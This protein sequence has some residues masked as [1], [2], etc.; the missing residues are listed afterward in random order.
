MER[1]LASMNVLLSDQFLWILVLMILVLLGLA[2]FFAA[3][4]FLLRLRTEKEARLWVRLEESWEPTLLEAL[5]DPGQL[6]ALWRKVGEQHHLH[7]LEFVLRYAQRL[8]GAERDALRKAA[9]PYLP[10]I[11]P[12]LKHRRMGIR[13][14]GV[15]TLGTLGL[16]QFADEIRDAVND[17]SPFVAAIAAR[18]LAH[19][20]GAE[21]ASDLC[22]SLARFDKFRIWYLVDM[23]TAM[24]PEASPAI[25]ETLENPEMPVRTRA[26]AAHALSVLRDLASADLAAKLTLKEKNPEFLAALL[27]LLAQVGT[28][29]HAPAARA[30]LD[31][32]EFFVR[33]AATRT[34]AELGREED[35]PFLVERLSDPSTW[36][37]MA[38]ARGVY[39][40][41]GKATLAALTQEDPANP[42][43]RQVLAE[44]AGR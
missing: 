19:E 1:F 8:E 23:V 28:S 17:P 25:R 35:L 26:V 27:R 2:L 11:L 39:R 36:V 38:A 34:L 30:H 37:K 13:A 32:E 40:L 29:K 12:L 10:E 44:E 22:L 15:Q 4:T 21:M 14:R 6:K 20:V 18:L 33:S 3:F 16:P 24:G 9:E 42:F 5:T 31:S 41:G 7:F 43:F